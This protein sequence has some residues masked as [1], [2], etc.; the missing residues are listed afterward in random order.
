MLYQILLFL[1]PTSSNHV[2]F[3]GLN[4]KILP[5]V[6]SRSVTQVAQQLCENLFYCEENHEVRSETK[7]LFLKPYL[8][9]C[10]N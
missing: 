1:L 10:K 9:L 7:A 5:P 4:L 2:D 8:Q 3:P 6:P